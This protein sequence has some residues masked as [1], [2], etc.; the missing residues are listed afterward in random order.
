MDEPHRGFPAVDDGDTTE[1]RLSLP[2][3]RHRPAGSRAGQSPDTC[4]TACLL[5]AGTRMSPVAHAGGR[6]L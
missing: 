5:P 3:E 2:S 1:H 6:G 4:L